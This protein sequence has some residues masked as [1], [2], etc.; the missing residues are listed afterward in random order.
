MYR[1]W[2]VTIGALFF[3]LHLFSQSTI[4]KEV[5]GNGFNY[6]SGGTSFLCAK[7]Y[8]YI[9][10]VD[11]YSVNFYRRIFNI[12]NWAGNLLVLTCFCLDWAFH[13]I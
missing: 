12:R 7:K 9:Y 1:I 11:I 6:S 10:D 3:S 13:V 2:L 8:N 5:R 4:D